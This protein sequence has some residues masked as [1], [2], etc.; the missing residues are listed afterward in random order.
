MSVPN[1]RF[2]LSSKSSSSV[3]DFLPKLRNFKRSVLL[4][5]TKSPSVSTS[6]AFRQFRA[7]T[8]R[9]MSVSLVFSN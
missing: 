9:F 4:Y 6:A 8:E 7:R 2:R 5:Y 3:S 1:D